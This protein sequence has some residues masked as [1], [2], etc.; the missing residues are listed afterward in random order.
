MSE[1]NY[2]DFKLAIM[3]VWDNPEE[4]DKLLNDPSVACYFEDWGG[5]PASN[6]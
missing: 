6:Y 2:Y 3:K 5:R 4:I 1:V